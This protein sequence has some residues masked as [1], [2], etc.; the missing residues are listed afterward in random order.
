MQKNEC[1]ELFSQLHATSRTL[2]GGAGIAIGASRLFI[3]FAQAVQSLRHRMY[4]GLAPSYALRL[5]P[6]V[7]RMT[8][9]SITTR[10][11]NEPLFQEV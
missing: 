3:L 2:I 4:V 7:E 11:T 9:K 6:L 5:L 1:T 8:L 10:R